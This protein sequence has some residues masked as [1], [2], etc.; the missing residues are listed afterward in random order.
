MDSYQK[1]ITLVQIINLSIKIAVYLFKRKR[2]IPRDLFS[3][4]IETEMLPGDIYD[5]I[6][7]SHM[8]TGTLKVR[9]VRVDRTRTPQEVLDA[10]DMAQYVN[11]AIVANMPRGEGE[12]VEVI[13]FKPSNYFFRNGLIR[14]E[15]LEKAYDLVGL[16][17]ADAY[18][19]CAVNAADPTFSEECPNGTHWKDA[20]GKWC[21]AAFDYWKGDG[22]NVY[23]NQHPYRWSEH[24]LF[25]GFRKKH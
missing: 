21:F 10:T 8:K 25:A 2:E 20:D 7:R 14:D 5:V 13:F 4:I 9:T 19:L 16:Y 18:S 11:G 17:P 3:Q 12:E 15:D 22:Y 6:M 24:Y 23:V 1:P